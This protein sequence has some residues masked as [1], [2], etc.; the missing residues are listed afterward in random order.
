MYVVFTLYLLLAIT[1]SFILIDPSRLDNITEILIKFLF[2]MTNLGFLFIG[3]FTILDISR[4]M[5]TEY[6]M[7]K[8]ELIN[9]KSNSSKL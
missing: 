7:I 3:I 5:K 9:N 4:T 2:P 8:K 6:E 1:T